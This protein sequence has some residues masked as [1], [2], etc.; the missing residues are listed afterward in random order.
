VEHEYWRGNGGRRLEI[1]TNGAGVDSVA[2]ASDKGGW[3]RTAQ[4]TINR[5][6]GVLVTTID[7]FAPEAVLTLALDVPSLLRSPEVE[8]FKP[9]EGAESGVRIG[10]GG[11]ESSLGLSFLDADPASGRLIRA[12]YVTDAGPVIMVMSGWKEA[13]PGVVYPSEVQVERANGSRETVTVR[14]LEVLPSAPANTF[15]RP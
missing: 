15:A 10:H 1:R 9:L 12:R 13:A 7:S 8:R 2:V 4:A 14:A 3:L 6:P 5:D 11:D